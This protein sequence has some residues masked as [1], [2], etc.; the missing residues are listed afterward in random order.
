MHVQPLATLPVAASVPSRFPAPQTYLPALVTMADDLPLEQV[1]DLAS[2]FSVCTVL[3]ASERQRMVPFEALWMIKDG[4]LRLAS[5]HL[6][7][8]EIV[9]AAGEAPFGTYRDRVDTSA[10]HWKNYGVCCDG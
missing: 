5:P 6:C 8:V 9:S 3:L 7:G 1:D 4:H 10:D 2:C